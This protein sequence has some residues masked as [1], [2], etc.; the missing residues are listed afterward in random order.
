M[1]DVDRLCPVPGTNF[2]FSNKCLGDFVGL[3]LPNLSF[4]TASTSALTV[5]M[6]TVRGD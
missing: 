2:T 4:L 1:P 6:N 5:V 3:V